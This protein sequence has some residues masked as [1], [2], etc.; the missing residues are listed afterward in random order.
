ML[1]MTMNPEIQDQCYQA[2][3]EVSTVRILVVDSAKNVA[4]QAIGDR[5]PHLSDRA[6]L[7]I[8]DA[9]ILETLR[10]RPPASMGLPRSPISDTKI[11]KKISAKKSKFYHLDFQ[12]IIP[13]RKAH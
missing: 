6:K 2:I 5:D 3:R 8:I 7:P 11:G 13:F 12:E 4:Q 1:Y 10:L 9:C